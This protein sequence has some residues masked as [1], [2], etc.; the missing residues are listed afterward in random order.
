MG[1]RPLKLNLRATSIGR[2]LKGRREE[3]R[4]D[5]NEGKGKRAVGIRIQV[6]MGEWWIEG[7]LRGWSTPRLWDS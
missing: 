7:A 2:D 1:A 4:E 5:R 6:V 3:G